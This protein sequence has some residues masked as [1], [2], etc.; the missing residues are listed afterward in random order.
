MA[1]DTLPS[2]RRAAVR[3][4]GSRWFDTVS[5][6]EICRQ[7]GVSNGV[8]YRYYRTK[9]E[10]FASL[11]D[12]FL[13]RFAA[14][15]RTVDGPT[16]P[17]RIRSFITVVTGAAP[18]YAGQVS[19]FREGQYRNPVY[20]QRLRAVYIETLER[21]YGRPVSEAEYLY[22]L[23]GL[24]FLATRSLYDHI[25]SDEKLLERILLH[26]VFPG[27]SGEVGLPPADKPGEH[28]PE[29]AR[30]RLT[31]AGI[32]LFG[33]R[34][35]HTVQVSDIV[36]EAGYSVGTFYNSFDSKEAFL[37]T[38]VGEI[39]HRT[40]RY[41]S[42]HAPAGVSRWEL[43][44]RGMWNFLNYFGR[45]PQY[46]EIVREAEFVAP[47][48]VREYYNAFDRGYREN[49]TGYPEHSRPVVANFLMGTSHYLGI[50]VLFSRGVANAE[51][52]VRALGALLATGVP[53]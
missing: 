31:E 9:D 37:A 13:E 33:E 10:L 53:G 19:M 7:A 48:A 17:G 25:S 11:L 18:R 32:R 26:G 24:R 15:L 40:R 42:E 38:I 29:T 16:L 21:I 23:S 50:E 5:V 30:D 52:S 36:R 49:L 44:V 47:A 51:A 12:E 20:E 22:L 35:F 39:G 6:A 2:I 43:E 46:Y 41:L 34:G 28:R 3:L 14:D 27:E 4:F 45:H 1:R 8:F